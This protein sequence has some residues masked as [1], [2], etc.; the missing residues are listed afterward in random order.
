MTEAFVTKFYKQIALNI[1]F[2]K[3]SVSVRRILEIK[4]TKDYE[5][6][7]IVFEKL[8]GKGKVEFIFLPGTDFDMEAFQFLRKNQ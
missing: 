1:E 8:V 7:E 3:E 4:G 2:S 6:Q 5:R